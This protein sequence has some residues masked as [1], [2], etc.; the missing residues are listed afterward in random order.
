MDSDFSSTPT[1]EIRGSVKLANVGDLS[2]LSSNSK[3]L[4]DFVYECY[5]GNSVWFLSS[6]AELEQWLAQSIAN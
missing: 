4:R 6:A 5:R 1:K 3:P 2:T